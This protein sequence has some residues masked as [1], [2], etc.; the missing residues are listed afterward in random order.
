MKKD[1]ITEIDYGSLGDLSKALNYGLGDRTGRTVSRR[2]TQGFKRVMNITDERMHDQNAEHIIHGAMLGTA[3][4]LLSKE[5]NKGL[6]LLGLACLIAFY[7]A[8]K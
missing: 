3:G 8:G 2:T 1:N 4:L 6:G 5:G 7:Q